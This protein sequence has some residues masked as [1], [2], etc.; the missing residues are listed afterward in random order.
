MKSARVPFY[1][2]SEF[3]P[4]LVKVP[5]YEFSNWKMVDFVFLPIFVT[6]AKPVFLISYPNLFWVEFE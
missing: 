2:L 6:T 1:R 5:V 4:I 3:L